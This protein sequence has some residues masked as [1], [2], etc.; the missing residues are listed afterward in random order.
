MFKKHVRMYGRKK[1]RSN[2]VFLFAKMASASKNI[3]QYFKKKDSCDVFQPPEL[4]HAATDNVTSAELQFA[5]NELKN[6]YKTRDKYTKDV[7]SKIKEEIAKYACENGT[8]N[9]LKKFSKKYPRY[10]FKRQTV[11]SW[12]YRFQKTK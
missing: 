8:S 7:P 12:K 11:T 3:L 10:D 5:E 1:K 9:A 2:A 6:G 4:L